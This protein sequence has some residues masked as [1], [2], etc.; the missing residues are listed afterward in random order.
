MDK[1]I[2]FNIPEDDTM[3]M[4]Y[5]M[6]MVRKKND[7]YFKKTGKRKKH[8]TVTYGCQMNEHDSEKIEWILVK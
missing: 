6:E 4:E 8:L 1:K 5:F 2:D 7:E 3:R